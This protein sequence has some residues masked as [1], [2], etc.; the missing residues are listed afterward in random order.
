MRHRNV[1]HDSEPQTSTTGLGGAALIN[2]VK[3]LG[4]SGQVNTVNTNP[5][6]FYDKVQLVAHPAPA[7]LNW[8]VITKLED[9]VL[10]QI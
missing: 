10:S 4:Y 9:S 8:I 6:V 1:L 2:P 7:K 5:P 3:T